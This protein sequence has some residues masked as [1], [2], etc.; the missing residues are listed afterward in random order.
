MYKKKLSIMWCLVGGL[1]LVIIIVIFCVLQYKSCKEETYRSDSPINFLSL[2]QTKHLLETDFDGYGS[3]LNLTNLKA[4]G[5]S[6]FPDLISKWS[7]SAMGWTLPQ[8]E[9]LKEAIKIVEHTITTRASILPTKKQ[10]SDIEWNFACTIHPYYLDGLSH[11]RGDIIFLS[12]KVVSQSSVKSL[13]GILLHEKIHIWQRKF[14]EDMKAWIAQKGF[15]ATHR[16]FDDSL[17]RS[18]PDTN[19]IIYKDLGVKFTSLNPLDLHS[20]K[21]NSSRDHP[22]EQMAY[23]IQKWVD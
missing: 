9:K 2:Q 15:E 8:Q 3:S 17:E 14:P 1:I 4:C 7:R 6:D 20:V 23:E 11:T 18:N 22:H 12:D 13:A 16:V 19:G 21:Y 5:V 10:L